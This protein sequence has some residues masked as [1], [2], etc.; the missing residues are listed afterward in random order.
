MNNTAT[1][2]ETLFERAEDYGKTSLELFKLSAIDK[3]A[4]VFSSLAVRFA[5]FMVGA[6]FTLVVNIG[7]AM[8]LGELLGKQ[9]YG[10]FVVAIFYALVM[11]LLYLFRNEWIKTPV[12]NS[13]ITQ[14][15]K[16]NEKE[17]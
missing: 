6:V 14:M 17:Y 15:T 5:I 8:W 10:F 11:S 16:Q 1:P 3:S 9:Y 12:S 13:I 4:D 2:I 7:I